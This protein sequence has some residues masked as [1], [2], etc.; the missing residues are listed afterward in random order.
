[1][2]AGKLGP[3]AGA[4]HAA[5]GGWRGRAQEVGG[6]TQAPPRQI[7]HLTA[8]A[9][10]SAVA[11]GPGSRG[12]RGLRLEGPEVRGGARAAAVGLVRVGSRLLARL[13][14]PGPSV[15]GWL[16]R[17]KRRSW[18]RRLR[19]PLCLRLGGRCRPQR[20]PLGRANP[21][22][23]EKRVWIRVCKLSL[24]G[25]QRLQRG[26]A[27]TAL[28]GRLSRDRGLP[29]PELEKPVEERSKASPRARGKERGWERPGVTRVAGRPAGQRAPAPRLRADAPT[30]SGCA[31]AP[32]ATKTLQ[33]AAACAICLDYFTDRVHRL[34]AQL[35]PSACNPAVGQGG[36]RCGGGHRRMGQLY[37]RGFVPA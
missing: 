21:E 35:L 13:R 37:S 6:E 4:V 2:Q 23:G 16:E 15:S 36:R 17:R 10:P 30:S 27:L 34:R 26:P 33:E 18:L 31:T 29:R 28:G 9:P 24:K 7:P 8:A 11:E 19:H 14:D 32:N 3:S 5:T 12:H 1:M 20:T 25:K 22:G